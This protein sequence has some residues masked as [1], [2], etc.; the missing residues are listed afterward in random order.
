MGKDDGCRASC[1]NWYGNVQPIFL[2]N[3]VFALMGYKLVEGR[4]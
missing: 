1:T 4:L 2:H 3:R